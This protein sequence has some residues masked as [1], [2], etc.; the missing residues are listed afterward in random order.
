MDGVPAPEHLQQMHEVGKRRLKSWA[1]TSSTPELESN[2]LPVG[3]FI[4]QIRVMHDK[5]DWSSI[6]TSLEYQFEM[7]NK[8]RQRTSRL[9]DFQLS[10]RGDELIIS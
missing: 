1:Q 4:F 10:F 3:L 5:R 6:A 9:N 2:D 7:N 8:S